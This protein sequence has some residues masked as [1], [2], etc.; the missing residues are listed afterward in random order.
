MGGFSTELVADLAKLPK[1]HLPFREK[2]SPED[3]GEEDAAQQ[4]SY[5]T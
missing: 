2:V 5:S 3:E 1:S 4:R